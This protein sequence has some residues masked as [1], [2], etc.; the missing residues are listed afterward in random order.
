MLLTQCPSDRS[1]SDH[2]YDLLHG[3]YDLL[4][5]D[6]TESICLGGAFS[7][8]AQGA[9]DRSVE[10]I[11]LCVLS[12][13]WEKSLQ[14]IVCAPS[15]SAILLSGSADTVSDV[16]KYLIGDVRVCFYKH[17]S[18][19]ENIGV[20]NVHGRLMKLYPANDIIRYKMAM[21]TDR[22]S[23]LTEAR[24]RIHMADIVSFLHRS[25]K[26]TRQSFLTIVPAL[27]KRVNIYCGSS[28]FSTR[29]DVVTNNDVRLEG[30]T[31]D[32]RLSSSSRNVEHSQ[33]SDFQ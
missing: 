10:S 14:M 25:S 27:V 3:I 18:F 21:L 29:Y 17:T 19:P 5:D 13:V 2:I 4:G 6:V 26:Q 28:G 8:N 32:I 23:T 31:F 15:W 12:S 33:R 7:L 11:D 24:L 9:V 22:S 1:V 30:L 16:A 20:I